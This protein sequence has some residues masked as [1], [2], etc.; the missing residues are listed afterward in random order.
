MIAVVG[1]NDHVFHRLRGQL[2]DV[3]HHCL[4][5][6]LIALSVG[7]ENAVARNHDHAHG[8]DD[9]P[10]GV[11]RVQSFIGIDVRRLFL[12]AREI[13]RLQAA[14]GDIAITYVRLLLGV[15]GDRAQQRTSQQRAKYP[16]CSHLASFKPSDPLLYKTAAK[17]AVKK[18]EYRS[19]NELDATCGNANPAG[20]A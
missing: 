16:N 20:I 3:I 15:H 17:A 13:T 12:P 10:A 14:L 18:T 8:V 6:R 11:R 7:N 9:L 2:L 1:R 4:A 19:G 5:L